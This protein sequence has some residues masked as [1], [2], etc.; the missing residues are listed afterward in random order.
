MKKYKVY[1]IRDKNKTIVYVGQTRTS[2]SNRMKVHRHQKKLDKTYTIELISD[3]DRPEPMFKLEAM[4][5]K[6][7][8]L[9]N[10]GLNNSYGYIDCPDK[11]D[12]DGEINAFYGHK[13][14]KKTKEKSRLRALG[15]KYAL[16]SKSRK[17]QKN[18]PEHQRKIVEANQKKV[19]C[20]DT[21]EVF[22]SAHH[23][24]KKL[25]LSNSQRQKI[26]MVCHGKRKTTGGY[27]FIFF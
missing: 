16:G 22:D 17:G 6:Q 26:S 9:V 20:V 3:F 19:I 27:K 23:A 15:N 14:T 25:G 18:T 1:C 13:H 7:Y 24:A 5:I 11:L 12:F 8:N 2:L 4:L 21:G 10:K